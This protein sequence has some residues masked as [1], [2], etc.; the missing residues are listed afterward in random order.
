MSD[1]TSSVRLWTLR[2]AW[3]CGDD[4]L[5]AAHWQPLLLQAGRVRPASSE[6]EAKGRVLCNVYDFKHMIVTVT[7]TPLWQMTNDQLFFLA[8]DE[9]TPY[10]RRMMAAEILG[11]RLQDEPEY[12]VKVPVEDDG[13]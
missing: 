12:S 6:Q 5:L 8:E 3:Y 1:G 9:L 7:R 13:A 10:D 11:E 2:Q 4:G